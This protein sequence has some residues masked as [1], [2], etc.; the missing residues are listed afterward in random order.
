MEM[1]ASGLRKNLKIEQRK[2]LLN[3]FHGVSN[4]A[5]IQRIASAAL[6]LQQRRQVINLHGMSRCINQ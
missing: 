2:H 3:L 6:D 1:V 4:N 5:K